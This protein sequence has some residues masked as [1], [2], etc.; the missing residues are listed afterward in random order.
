MLQAQ[1]VR[2]VLLEPRV[3]QG[4]Q[5]PQVLRALQVQARAGLLGVL[6]VACLILLVSISPTTYVRNQLPQ[7]IVGVGTV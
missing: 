1:R 3:R 2:Q 6:G 5:E 4:Q 7:L